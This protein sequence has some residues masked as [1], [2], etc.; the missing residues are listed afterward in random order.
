MEDQLNKGL[1][2]EPNPSNSRTAWTAWPEG[3]RGPLGGWGA[4]WALLLHDPDHCGRDTCETIA[5]DHELPE[6]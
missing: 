5:L 4:D 3:S 1:R 2:P 6:G